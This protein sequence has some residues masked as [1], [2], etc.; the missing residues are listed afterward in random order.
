MDDMRRSCDRD[1]EID[2]GKMPAKNEVMAI[3]VLNMSNVNS[4]SISLDVRVQA[5]Q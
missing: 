3:S 2:R 1:S 5:E 4:P